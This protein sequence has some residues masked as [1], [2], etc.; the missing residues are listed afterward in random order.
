MALHPESLVE[1]TFLGIPHTGHDKTDE[2]VH[3]GKHWL[4]HN[5]DELGD[6]LDKEANAIVEQAVAAAHAA[7]AMVGTDALRSLLHSLLGLA[8]HVAPNRSAEIPIIPFT[9]FTPGI[10]LSL[11]IKDNLGT[12]RKWA[13]HPPHGKADYMAMLRELADDEYVIVH[14]PNGVGKIPVQIRMIDQEIEKLL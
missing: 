13:A 3:K 5:A 14:L 4:E 11:N 1:S 2:W 7:L 6:E 12:I 8:E 10:G 9:V